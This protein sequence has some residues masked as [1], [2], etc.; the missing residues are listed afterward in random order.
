MKADGKLPESISALRSL[1]FDSGSPD[2]EVQ[3]RMFV[4]AV[5]NGTGEKLPKA[6]YTDILNEIIQ[7]ERANAA[8]EAQKQLTLTFLKAFEA[9][10]YFLV[11]DFSGSEPHPQLELE[12]LEDFVELV[13]TTIEDPDIPLHNDEE[14]IELA[15]DAVQAALHSEQKGEA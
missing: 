9:K 10:A 1:M 2:L 12:M 11:S 6:Y 3:L 7:A 13:K 15:V 14:T 8:V 5:R 4:S